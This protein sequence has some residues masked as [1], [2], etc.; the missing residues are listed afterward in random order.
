MDI[1]A[2][3]VGGFLERHPLIMVTGMTHQAS[4]TTE[5]R[6]MT[7]TT[8]QSEALM[9]KENRGEELIQEDIHSAVPGQFR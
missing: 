7:M 1:L 6:G 8:T 9:E 2:L 4:G 3:M 5:H